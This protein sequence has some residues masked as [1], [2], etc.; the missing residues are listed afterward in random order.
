M[1]IIDEVLVEEPVV[2]SHFLCDLQQ[3]KGAC[4]TLAGAKGAPLED[5]EIFEIENVLPYA[6]RFLSP[7][8]IEVI[9][10]NG[11]YEGVKGYYTT[12]CIEHHECV[13]VFYEDGI[14]RCSIEKAY[15]EGLTKWRKPISCHLFPLRLTH[16]VRPR[17]YY[18]EI[19]ECSPAVKQGNVQ[20]VP[21]STFVKEA[22][23]RKFG[24]RWYEQF[25]KEVEK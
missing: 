23:V 16:E 7:R 5:E 11:W 17:L 14:A 13:F 25:S 15:D 3:C 18:E 12:Q 22:L 4:C 8:S 10:R 2:R 9:E 6:K 24:E 19:P 21:V 1:M 20:R